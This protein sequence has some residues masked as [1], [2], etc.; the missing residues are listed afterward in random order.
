M[1]GE[2]ESLDIGDSLVKVR[3]EVDVA[4]E[5]DF[6]ENLPTFSLGKALSVACPSTQ[7]LKTMDEEDALNLDWEEL[8]SFEPES[9]TSRLMVIEAERKAAELIDEDSVGFQN[10]A[11]LE[12]L[13]DTNLS[14]PST[15]KTH[16]SMSCNSTATEPGRYGPKTDR[17]S[18]SSYLITSS[19][20][21]F[22]RTLKRFR[23]R[24][25]RS[26]FWAYAEEWCKYHLDGLREYF[27][28]DFH[29]KTALALTQLVISRGSSK[30]EMVQFDKTH[31]HNMLLSRINIRSQDIDELTMSQESREEMTDSQIVALKLLIHCKFEALARVRASID[32]EWCVSEVVRYINQ[33]LLDQLSLAQKT[34]LL[35]LIEVCLAPYVCIPFA[36]AI[37]QI[38]RNYKHRYAIALAHRVSILSPES[39]RKFLETI[40]SD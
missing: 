4:Q 32:T 17:S 8:I 22:S 30:E 24:L 10:E 19:E 7:T 18:C 40:H 5:M 16:S 14:K 25:S 36:R 2:D 20:P 15:H 29:S 33:R 3:K 9:S 37:H 38:F 28:K 31:H 26:P 11:L 27:M 6:S 13:S 39:Y 34:F 21:R 1:G 35:N 23:L 12:G